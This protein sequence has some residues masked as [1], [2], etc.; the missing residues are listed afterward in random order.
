MPV[1]E[2]C[3][4]P[5][6]PNL[7]IFNHCC[8]FMLLPLGSCQH[9]H[10]F[11]ASCVHSL[12][13]NAFTGPRSVYNGESAVRWML[14]LMAF[15]LTLGRHTSISFFITA[16]LIH[17]QDSSSAPSSVF[18][19]N[20]PCKGSGLQTPVHGHDFFSPVIQVSQI[21]FGSFHNACT[22]P[23]HLYGPGIDSQNQVA[24]I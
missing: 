18:C 24:T 17:F 8:Y 16:L 11:C 20:V 15:I 1:S 19:N 9:L 22:I 12:T 2:D 21:L 23:Q 6:A 14:H 3:S 5:H 10:S 4:I 7:F 13:M